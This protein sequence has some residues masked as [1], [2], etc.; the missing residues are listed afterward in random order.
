MTYQVFARIINCSGVTRGKWSFVRSYR[1]SNVNIIKDVSSTSK[2]NRAKFLEHAH[3][4]KLGSET[5][6][7]WINVRPWRQKLAE[8]RRIVF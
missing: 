5:K 4:L 1:L 6:P 2:K 8:T 7:M 3:I